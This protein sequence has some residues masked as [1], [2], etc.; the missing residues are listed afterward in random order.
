MTDIKSDQVRNKRKRSPILAAVIVII[1]LLLV[2]LTLAFLTSFDEVTNV[3]EGGHVD[4]VLTEEH[5]KPEE[6]KNIVPGKVLDKDPRIMNDDV[7][8]TY[9]FL[10]VTVPY[11]DLEIESEADADKGARLSADTTAVPL[12][13]FIDENGN[14]DQT[15]TSAQKINTAGWMLMSGYPVQ[16]TEKKTY[17]YLYAHVRIDEPEKMSPLMPGVTTRKPLFNQIKLVNFNE[18]EFDRSRNYS[19]K[20]KAYGIQANYL[21]ENNQTTDDPAE[22]WS[23]LNS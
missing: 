5:W 20:V 6:A 1:L 7:T 23:I 3:F 22:V 16:D 17:R 4:I 13:K 2:I 8:D 11:D 9:V 12:Y 18:K 19:V 15:Y 14:Y 10:E 21:K